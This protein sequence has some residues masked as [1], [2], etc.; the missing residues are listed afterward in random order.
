M[1]T[2]SMVATTQ[3]LPLFLLLFLVSAGTLFAQGRRMSPE[4][5]KQVFDSNFA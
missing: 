3:R 4:E 1:S 5:M 2:K